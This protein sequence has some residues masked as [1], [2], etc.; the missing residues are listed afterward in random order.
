[1]DG[2]G[3]ILKMILILKRKK[4]AKIKDLTCLIFVANMII[5]FLNMPFS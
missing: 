3:N 1:M 4:K 2:L 5:A